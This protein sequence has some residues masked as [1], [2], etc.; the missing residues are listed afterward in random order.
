MLHL[1][2]LSIRHPRAALAVWGAVAVV[3]V[4]VGLGVSRSLSPSIAVVPGSEASRHRRSAQR[5]CP[6]T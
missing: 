6:P 3:L 4:L 1:A 2:S 5:C